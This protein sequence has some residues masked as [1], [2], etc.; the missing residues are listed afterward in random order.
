MKIWKICIFLIFNLLQFVFI[1]FIVFFS[2]ENEKTRFYQK[3][4]TKLAGQL[5]ITDFCLSTENRHTRH[6]NTFEPMGVFQDAP[7]FY[8]YFPSSVFWETDTKRKLGV[9]E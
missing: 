8:D 9:K 3:E 1:F 6:P 5:L 4:K 2:K 7:A